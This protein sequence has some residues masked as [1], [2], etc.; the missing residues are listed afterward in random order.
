VANI[1]LKDGAGS[2]LSVGSYVDA[3]GNLA[4]GHVP[5]VGGLPVATANPLPVVVATPGRPTP[6]PQ[7]TA[8]SSGC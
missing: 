2:N 8:P 4:I 3:N 6:R 1:T 5:L 7:A